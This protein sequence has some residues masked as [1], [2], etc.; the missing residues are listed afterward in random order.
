M[1]ATAASAVSPPITLVYV[2]DPGSDVTVGAVG[3]T[4]QPPPTTRRRR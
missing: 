1:A 2:R 4:V 3:I